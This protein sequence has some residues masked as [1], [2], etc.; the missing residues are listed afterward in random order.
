MRRT[1]I[2]LIAVIPLNIIAFSS[3]AQLS[4]TYLIGPTAPVYKTINQA[5]QDLYLSH[6]VKG[7]VVFNIQDGVYDEQVYIPQINNSSAINLV[8]FKS[9]S[10]DSTKVI[11]KFKPNNDTFNYTLMLDGAN[12]LVFK[13]LTFATDTIFGRVIDINN[14]CTINQF[15]G[16]RIIGVPGSKELVY[17]ES[18]S[19]SWD[20]YN[21]FQNNLFQFGSVGISFYG[22]DTTTMEEGNEIFLNK[23]IDQSQQA[24]DLKYSYKFKIHDNSISTSVGTSD[25]TGIR[26]QFCHDKFYIEKNKLDIKNQ[27]QPTHGIAILFSNGTGS[28]N[29]SSISNNFIHIEANTYVYAAALEI[30]GSTYK[31]FNYNSVNLTGNNDGFI[32]FNDIS[33]S[34]INIFNNIFSAQSTGLALLLNDT[35]NIF[36]DYNDIFSKDSNLASN[37]T[38]IYSTLSAWNSASKQDLHSISTDPLFFSNSDLHTKNFRLS[39]RGKTISGISDDIDGNPRKLP[40]TDIGADEFNYK[41]DLGPDRYICA[42]SSTTFLADK[43]FDSYLWSNGSSSD[44]ITFDSTG[45][46]LGVKKVKLSVTY[47]ADHYSDS[48]LVHFIKAHANPGPD[49]AVCEDEPVTLQATGGVKFK[50]NTGDSTSTINFTA[51]QSAGYSVTVTDQ[52]GCVDSASVKVFVKPRPA[53]PTIILFGSDSLKSSVFGST[54]RWYLNKTVL[55]DNTISIKAYLNGTYQLIVYDSACHSD[56]SAGYD[57]KKNS[58]DNFHIRSQIRLYPNPVINK[59]IIDASDFDLSGSEI[60]IISALGE[61]VYYSNKN[62]PKIEI[63]TSAYKKG[64]YIFKFITNG[65]TIVNRFVVE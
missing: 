16:N 8:T 9:L 65:Q 1:L 55:T 59:L 61:K 13:K 49:K 15:I 40:K 17:S 58:I 20:N 30:L 4:G 22:V 50:W 38:N 23:F 60:E 42:G 35:T 2:Y 31:N 25:Y 62:S 11:I 28:A 46:G 34:G 63:E 54:Y 41:L 32:G 43:G 44:S 5:I 6:G 53:T 45:I 18:T 3:N 10:G 27:S 14:Q 21:R 56:T 48:A 57:F 52:Y 37:G 36:C 29:A 12:F 47:Q 51:T 26:I 64:L 39:K 7:P 19:N 33:A 24:I